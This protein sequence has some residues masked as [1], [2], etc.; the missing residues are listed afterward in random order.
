MARLSLLLSMNAVLLA[1]G[2]PQGVGSGAPD[3]DD[4]TDSSCAGSLTSCDGACFDLTSDLNNCG[5]C[6]NQCA[7]NQA[8]QSGTCG[9]PGGQTL[10]GSF[11]TVTASDPDNCGTCGNV[12]GNGGTCQNSQCV[13]GGVGFTSPPCTPELQP[14]GAPYPDATASC[15]G[16]QAENFI[17]MTGASYQ[18]CS[19]GCAGPGNNT[20]CLNGTECLEVNSWPSPWYQ[21]L[22][23]TQNNGLNV[24]GGCPANMSVTSSVDSPAVSYCQPN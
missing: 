20:Q 2:G 8:C 16:S 22:L 17:C 23:P 14:S 3:R 9:C 6:G 24:N 1:C 11:C 18:Y 5:Q 12:C 19:P 15:S 7:G 10:C 13:G 21:C 4:N